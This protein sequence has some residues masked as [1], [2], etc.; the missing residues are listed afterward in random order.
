MT[1]N[2]NRADVKVK[3][4][5]HSRRVWVACVDCGKKRWVTLKRGKPE[6][7]RCKR[8]SRLAE[9]HWNWRGNDIAHQT[10]WSRARAIP[11]QPCRI[12]GAS[13]QRH[14]I[15]GDNRNNDPRNIDFLCV[16]HHMIKDGRMLQ[17]RGY[18]GRYIPT[19]AKE[20]DEQIS[21]PRLFQFGG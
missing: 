7:P 8:C 19:E 4:V 21:Q 11:L 17:P 13:G 16:R 2:P 18:H 5:G 12:C 3:N 14:H 9:K 1:K 10:G 15:D 6:S 20:R